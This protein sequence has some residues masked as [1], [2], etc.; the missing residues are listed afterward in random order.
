MAALIDSSIL[1][2]SERG[3]LDL[4]AM[5]KTHSSEQLAIS[6][7][8]ASE[9]LHGV[10]RASNAAQKAKRQA[11]VEPILSRLPIIA[12]DLVAARVHAGL[13][14]SLAAAGVQVGAHDLMIA[15]TAISIGY[16]VVTHDMRSFPKIPGLTVVRWAN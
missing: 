1:I 9:L 15:A 4:H 5:L 3:K 14:A 13:W 16:D 11:F 10:H 7:V 2:A 12:F 8:T 6:S